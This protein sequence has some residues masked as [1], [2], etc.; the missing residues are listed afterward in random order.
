M[1]EEQM[2]ELKKRVLGGE[3]DPMLRLCLKEI[4]RLRLHVSCD[5]GSDCP[6]CDLGSDCPCYITGLNDS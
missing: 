3:C 2:A 6:D 4:E 1:N 5:L